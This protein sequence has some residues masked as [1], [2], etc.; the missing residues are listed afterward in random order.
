MNKPVFNPFNP[1]FRANPYPF[2][3]AL[4]EQEPV[5][6]TPY[7][8]VILTRFEDVSWTLRSNDFSRDIDATANEPTEPLAKAKWNRRQDR[9]G[10]KTI[11][12][13]DPPDH[14]RLRRLVSKAF[15]PTAI[16][17]LRPRIQQLVDDVLDRSAKSGGMELV[18]DLAFPIPFQVISDLLNMPTDRA[19]D[20]HQ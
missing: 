13:L 6:V 3:D 2:Y 7:G 18:D 15:T 1:A 20:R 12:N 5:H 8:N 17:R 4:R 14:T 16:D 9:S 19:E 11:L 10:A